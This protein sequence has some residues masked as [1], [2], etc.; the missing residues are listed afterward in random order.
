M[1]RSASQRP[2]RHIEPKFDAPYPAA[3]E[4]RRPRPPRG[5][6]LDQLFGMT[7]AR[8]WGERLAFDVAEY[9]AGRVAWS[10]LDHACVLHGPPGTGKTTFATAL[11][12]SCKLPLVKTAFGAWQASGEGHLGS[13]L[14]AFD[15][16]FES[17]RKATPCILFIDELDSLPKRGGSSRDSYMNNVVNHVLTRLDDLQKTEGVIVLGACNH[18]YQLDDALIRSGRFDQ[19]IPIELPTVKDIP[20]IILYHLGLL[21]VEHKQPDLSDVAI[22]CQGFSGADIERL[23]REAKRMA[24]VSGRPK[25]LNKTDLFAAIEQMRPLPDENTLRR[26]AVHEA[27]HAIAAFRYGLGEDLS[28][29]LHSKNGLGVTN[30]RFPTH[31]ITRDTAEQRMTVH[32][33]GRAA[34]EVVLGSVSSGA[35]GNEDSDIARATSL[36]TDCVARLGLSQSGLTPWVNPPYAHD[37]SY[38]NQDTSQEVR[39]MLK[40]AY[41][42]AI[43][44]MTAETT[45]LN[46]IANALVKKKALSY[47]D[48]RRL[49]P[50]TGAIW[51][52]DPSVLKK[53]DTPPSSRSGR[54]SRYK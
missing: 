53:F 9:H 2:S 30:I 49:D 17:A 16:A 40:E 4:I 1:E 3:P 50:C 39:T 14:A 46:A 19:L 34:E 25:K 41:D 8:A 11:A 47:H 27:G 21:S 45:Y 12:A 22:L 37:L 24:R 32:L 29:T 28:I 42:R 38:Y 35:G 6:K 31:A 43:S 48:I 51:D 52:I 15:E 7:K 36:A 26:V 20:K 54:P 13:T 10:E 33:A 5:P 18:P 44:L 23:V